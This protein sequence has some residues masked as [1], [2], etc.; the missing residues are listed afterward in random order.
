[1]ALPAAVLVACAAI[2]GASDLTIVEAGPSAD[3]GKDVEQPPETDA[4]FVS[5]GE[6]RVCLPAPSGWTP[7]VLVQ[8][9]PANA[10][11]PTTY[12]Q[13][14]AVKGLT[15]LAKC[16]CRCDAP[17]GGGACDNDLRIDYGNGQCSAAGADVSALP[18]GGCTPVTLAA[19]AGSARAKPLTG[20]A[21]T[22]SPQITQELPQ[23]V[24]L[25][26]CAGAEV[27]TSAQC[28]SDESCVPV[29]S[30]GSKLCIA[31]EGEIECPAGTW[32]RWSTGTN[33]T[34]D[35]ACS[36]C[37]CSSD[38]TGCSKGQL[39]F[40]ANDGCTG[41][42]GTLTTDDTCK[43]SPVTAA[44]RSVQYKAGATCSVTKEPAITGALS[45]QGARTVCC[46]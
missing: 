1:M 11:C 9:A 20:A 16:A 3:A 27:T 35:R 10:L 32:T 37:T 43:A 19:L 25:A 39:T 15:G 36:G 13:K 31:H 30:R 22:C 4:G 12:A 28:R 29:V 41:P 8:G 23:P 2:T 45:F 18:D 46:L 26:L 44:S 38:P 6:Q 42:L 21:T 5:C 7:I 17:T 34:D 24:D 14:S 33:P 40:Y